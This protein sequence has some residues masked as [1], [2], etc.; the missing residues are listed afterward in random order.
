MRLTSESG[1]PD[2][3]A[4]GESQVDPVEF[5]IEQLYQGW[6][7]T[8]I[9]QQI[10]HFPGKQQEALLVDLAQRMQFGTQATPLQKAL[11][12][13]GID[14]QVY[15]HPLPEDIKERKRHTALLSYAYKR[16]AHSLRT[17]VLTDAS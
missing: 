13:V 8:Q 5:A 3:V 7:F 9:A 6:L 2:V 14:I 11:L 15:C 1:S 10:A 17:L 12:Q 16:L 4:N